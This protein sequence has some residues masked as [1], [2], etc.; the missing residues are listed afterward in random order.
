VAALVTTGRE[1]GTLSS[2]RALLDVAAVARTQDDL[3]RLLEAM[4]APIARELGFTAVIV[5][6]YRPAWDDYEVVVAEDPDEAAREKLM[7]LKVSPADLEKLLLE[8]F[9]RHGAYL[10]P[11]D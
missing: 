3:R 4:A 9:R 7:G 11:H 6:V 8:R 5:N 2:L 10:V 1:A